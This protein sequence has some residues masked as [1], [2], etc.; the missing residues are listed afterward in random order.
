[1]QAIRHNKQLSQQIDKMDVTIGLLVQNRISLQVRLVKQ[2]YCK[3]CVGGGTDGIIAVM[4]V[5]QSHNI[6]LF[7]FAHLSLMLSV[8]GCWSQTN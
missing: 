4:I 2:G 7:W 1:M 8:M 6:V 3:S 5:E